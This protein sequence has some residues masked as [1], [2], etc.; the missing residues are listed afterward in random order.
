MHGVTN[1]AE[2]RTDQCAANYKTSSHRHAGSKQHMRCSYFTALE[3]Y[4]V[5]QNMAHDQDTA[6]SAHPALTTTHCPAAIPQLAFTPQ[7]L[8]MGTSRLVRAL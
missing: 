5:Q 8:G 6:Q 4:T 2:T 7:H 3:L 1:Q